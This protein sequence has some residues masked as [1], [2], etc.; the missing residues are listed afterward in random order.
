MFSTLSSYIYFPA[1]VPMANDLGVSISL[2]NLTVTSYLIVAGIAPA[3]MGDI[4]DQGG[5][6]PAYILMFILV[7]ASNVGLALQNSYAALFVLRMVQSAGASGSYGAAYGIIADTTTVAERGSFVGSLILFTNAAPSFGPVIAGVLAQKLGWRWIFWFLVIMT[8]SYLVIVILLIPET[9]RKVVGNGSIPPRGIHKS[10]FETLSRKRRCRGENNDGHVET[11]IAQPADTKKARRCQIPNPFT[12]IPML[13]L[14]GNL[15]VILIGSITYAVKMTLQTSLAA[16]CIEIYD[17]DYLQAGLIYLPSGVGGALASYT[18]GKF[19]DRNIKKCSAKAGREEYKKGEDIFDFP[20]ER[21]RFGGIYSLIVVSSV[22]SAAYGV[23]LNERTHLAVPLVLQFLTGAATSSIFTL[24]GTLL[25]DLNPNASATVQ[26]SYNLVRCLGAGAA[27]AAQQP[28]A[29]AAGSR[30]CFGVFAII[31]LVALPLSMLIEKRGL[32]WRRARASKDS[33][34]AWARDALRNA[35][36]ALL[37]TSSSSSSILA[38][39]DVVDSNEE[40]GDPLDLV[41]PDKLEYLLKLVQALFNARFIAG[42]YNIAVLLTIAAFAILHWRKSRNDRQKW[43]ARIKGRNSDSAQKTTAR[44][45]KTTQT[46]SSPASSSRSSPGTSTP[47]GGDWKDNLVDLE[48]SPLLRGRTSSLTINSTH[49]DRKPS[50]AN[51]I[52]SWLARQPPP[53]PIVNRTLPC[54]G[55]SLFIVLWISL[56][57]FFQMLFI[58][59]RWDFF[60]VFGDKMGFM[61]IVNLPLLYLLSAK[62]Q[63]LR[64][65]TGYSYEALNIF[66][67]RVGEMM[68]FMALVHFV[69]MVTWQFVLAEDWML[70]SKSAWA[71]FTHPLI[72]NGLGAFASYELLY[73][74]SLGSFRQRWYELFLAWHVLLQIAALMFLWFHFYTSRPYVS[75]SLLIF[76]LDRLVWRLR[77]KRATVTADIEVLEDGQTYLLS[78]DWDII[79]SAQSQPSQ[80]QP[81]PWWKFNSNKSIL[82]GWNPTDHVFLSVPSLGGSHALQAHPFTIASAAPVVTSAQQQPTHAWFN[83]LIRSYSGFTSDLLRHAQAGHTRVAVQLD[84]PYGSSH[85][86]DMLRASGS[87][88]LVAGGSG[89]AVTFPL[90]WALLQRP[91][92][93]LSDGEDDDLDDDDE[94]EEEDK[95]VKSGRP[96]TRHKQRVHMLWVTH[97]RSHRNWVPQ[98]QFDE[99]V[100]LG[101]DLVV[102]EPTEE[103]GRPD[104]AGIVK[105]WIL[106]AASDGLESAVVASGPDGL[107]RTVR[108]TCADVIGEGLD[109]RIAVE[110]FGW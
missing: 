45:T 31:M 67:R 70:A 23:S 66:H 87:A 72:L 85:A 92:E 59:L 69:S 97:S 6:R 30:W 7:A 46:S 47:T 56:N 84:G 35:I 20:I 88:I 82:N 3:F 108:N 62:N 26:A 104:V 8:G 15:V 44:T 41:P 74:T 38:V 11:Q 83:L 105:G 81:Q 18:T 91:E 2:I 68:C 48:R 57:V 40:G 96:L 43:V 28:L 76:V 13:F 64:L 77:F 93:V 17:L 22:G 65:L 79:P 80:R 19:L 89:I 107:N 75:L 37:S 42:C 102:P 33:R 49:L 24:C 99:L 32:E 14:K 16:Q 106:D 103:A 25:T 52:S 110:K 90:V 50:L 53:I 36:S 101:L 5:R 60:F 34:G 21:A 29:D 109:V 61:F 10:L 55:T 9:Q 51:T 1:L 95:I 63:P 94:E 86:L 78:A 71:Y 27:I 58:P 12:C 39:R 100:A 73:F 54:N 98:E 4:A